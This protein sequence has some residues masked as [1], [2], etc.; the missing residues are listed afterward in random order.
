MGSLIAVAFWLPTS[1]RATR[2]ILFTHESFTPAFALFYTEKTSKR[3]RG[4]QEK[5][6][7]RIRI[8]WTYRH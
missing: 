4:F 1:V 5:T 8:T 6:V 3:E 7:I 2:E